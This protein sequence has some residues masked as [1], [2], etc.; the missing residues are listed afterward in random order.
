MSRLMAVDMLLF[1]LAYGG[2]Y[3]ARWL[4]IGDVHRIAEAPM[5]INVQLEIDGPITQI[6]DSELVYTPGGI[7]ND[8]ETTTWVEYRLATDPHAER[9]VHRSVNMR[10]KK[11][12][13]G[14]LIAASF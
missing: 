12:V 5:L 13:F 4:S 14:D 8:V 9:A 2:G 10:L 3:K 11:G 1:S 6:D 7:D